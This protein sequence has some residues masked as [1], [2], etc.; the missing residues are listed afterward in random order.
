MKD[1]ITSNALLLKESGRWDREVIEEL[2]QASNMLHEMLNNALEM[3]KLEEGKLEFNKKY[4]SIHNIIDIILGIIKPSASKKSIALSGECDSNVPPLVELDRFRVTQVV[5]N[6]L[7][8]AIKFTAEGGQVSVRVKWYPK[9]IRGADAGRERRLQ[10][11]FS[12]DDSS[13][14]ESDMKTSMKLAL[15]NCGVLPYY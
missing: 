1:S 14:L 12:A 15:K 4:D 9:A 6:L 5:M 2:F 8:N 7:G 10:K 13:L 11:A 3:S